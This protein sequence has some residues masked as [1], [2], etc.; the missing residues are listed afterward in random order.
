M[1]GGGDPTNAMAGASGPAQAYGY[2]QNVAPAAALTSPGQMPQWQ[3]GLMGLL[4]GSPQYGKNAP[5]IH[6]ALTGMLQPKQQQPI[7]ASPMAPR[8]GGQ[9]MAFPGLPPQMQ[10]QQPSFGQPPQIQ[11]LAP[12]MGR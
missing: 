3:Q 11:P 2:A 6:Q 7:M 1:S 8:M 5:Q 10:A 9:A 4:T 12:W